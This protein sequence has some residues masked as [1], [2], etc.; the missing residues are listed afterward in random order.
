MCSERAPLGHWM[1]KNAHVQ[2]TAYFFGMPCEGPVSNAHVRIAMGHVWMMIHDHVCAGT[3]A[4]SVAWFAQGMS[5][6]RCIIDMLRCSAVYSIRVSLPLGPPHWSYSASTQR[7][8]VHKPKMFPT[9]T[10]ASFPTQVCR[11]SYHARGSKKMYSK[12]KLYTLHVL[13]GLWRHIEH[14]LCASEY[15]R[16]NRMVLSSFRKPLRI[17]THNWFVTFCWSQKLKN[18]TLTNSPKSVLLSFIS[19]QSGTR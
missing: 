12:M 2:F 19:P 13:F 3:V 10:K 15:Q 14:A 16:Q 7:K 1:Y 17:R 9:P 8:H 6:C 4:Y 11:N 18:D 5:H